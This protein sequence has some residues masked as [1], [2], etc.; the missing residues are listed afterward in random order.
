MKKPDPVIGPG[1]YR[2]YGVAL[3]LT[4]PLHIG[5][6][7]AFG[8][9]LYVIFHFFAVAETFVPAET[10]DVIAVNKDIFAPVGGFN[11]AEAFFGIE[12]LDFTLCHGVVL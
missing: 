7:E 10:V 12:P 4:E 8:R 9:A 5:C 1:L 2:M 6:A 11:E 3:G